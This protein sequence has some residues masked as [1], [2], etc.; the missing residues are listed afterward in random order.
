MENSSSTNDYAER[1]FRSVHLMIEDQ[2]AAHPQDIAIEA[3]DGNVTYE[4]LN[5]ISSQLAAFLVKHICQGEIVPLCFQK[6]KW[7]ALAMLAV[8]KAGGA[9]VLFDLS[10]PTERLERMYQVTGASTI[11]TSGPVYR[12]GLINQFLSGLDTTCILVDEETMSESS[13]FIAKPIPPGNG[14][15]VV[16]TSGTTGNPKGIV[17][18]HRAMATS[19]IKTS[20]PIGLVRTSRVLQFAS[21]SFDLG[22]YDHLF[23]L[24]CGACLCVPDE[25]DLR[26]GAL[27]VFEKFDV[28]WATL[29]PSLARTLGPNALWA[30][31][32][33][34]LAGERLTR[35]D[36]F[37][38]NPKTRVLGLYGPAEFVASATIKDFGRHR[39]IRQ[40]ADPADLGSS[41]SA[42]CWVISPGDPSKLLE[43][44]QGELVLEGPCLSEGYLGTGAGTV[45]PS[46][47]PFFAFAPWQVPHDQPS[48]FYMTGDLVEVSRR[49]DGQ[50]VLKFRGRKDRQIKLNGQRIEPGEVE[51]TISMFF[52]QRYTGE[53]IDVFVDI[54]HSSLG[55]NG[56]L[57]A[58]IKRPLHSHEP[59]LR[60]TAGTLFSERVTDSLT[61]FL[62]MRVS[63][64]MVPSK[65]IFINEFPLTATGKINT[66]ELGRLVE[67]DQD[68]TPGGIV[69]TSHR[70]GGEGDE[71]R[72]IL[73]EIF[74]V[75]LDRHKDN[76]KQHLKLTDQGGDSLCAMKIVGRAHVKGILVTMPEI[77]SLPISCITIRLAPPKLMVGSTKSIDKRVFDVAHQIFEKPIESVHPCTGEQLEM[78]PSLLMVNTPLNLTLLLECD[79][80]PL[81]DANRLA[82][83]W[84]QVVLSNPI[85]RTRLFEVNG[86]FYQA[87]LDDM[88]PLGLEGSSK[89]TQGNVPNLFTL[90][91]PL[92][93]LEFDGKTLRMLIHH[94]L[95]DGC[96]LPLVL[97]DLAQAYHGLP[98]TRFN[99]SGFIDRASSLDAKKRSFWTQR[100]SGSDTFPSARLNRPYLANDVIIRSLRFLSTET[101]S[102]SAQLRLSLGLTLAQYCQS[103][104]VVFGEMLARREGPGLSE[105]PAPT[106][107]VLP[108]V[109]QLPV[110]ISLYETLENVRM[111]V[112]EQMEYSDVSLAQLRELGGAVKAACDFQT[113]L[114]IQPK[115]VGN[116]SGMFKDSKTSYG[117]ALARWGICLE[118][119]ITSRTLKTHFD[120]SALDKS[121]TMV[122]VD[123]LEANLTM[124]SSALSPESLRVTVA[125]RRISRSSGYRHRASLGHAGRPLG[126]S[127][128]T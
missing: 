48:R 79:L 71:L 106:A 101:Y 93:R 55:N 17:V 61:Q 12:S 49:P 31:D 50:Q 59:S 44:G 86:Q 13:T 74:A 128:A 104:K 100:L 42:I 65:L 53:P 14:L 41:P 19:I 16:F 54:V 47:S 51:G 121:Q 37:R 126:K 23:T 84:G 80:Q 8:I 69:S 113:V 73:R 90:G 116:F 52:M 15:Y 124:V 4:E 32:V 43:E 89:W 122:F 82:R 6:S 99:Y 78:L 105:I 110:N 26:E 28:N 40:G 2:C 68:R 57:A 29:T 76:V 62:K 10:V 70:G 66:I 72:E 125:G 18:S 46:H 33:L 96:S 109:I 22:V 85:I 119:D 127:F 107:A 36:I 120:S 118:F 25:F 98:L 102:I 67:K 123:S 111:Q 60:H 20:G 115:E 112:A 30:L 103:S 63:P 24:A 39:D 7:T 58:F 94:L 27:G 95:F 77:L 92:V 56:V 64:Y 35:E 88:I 11:L 5:R 81:L 87:V 97:R 114:I 9:F 3:W 45:K 21:Y 91:A 83:A 34:A 117:N 38:W 1:P 108:M 75:A